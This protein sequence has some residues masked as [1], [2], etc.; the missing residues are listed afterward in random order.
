[1]R[2]RWW[3]KALRPL[4]SS[5]ADPG[6]G[7]VLDAPDAVLEELPDDAS[8]EAVAV[9]GYRMGYLNALVDAEEALLRANP[10]RR[11]S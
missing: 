1:M 8:K 11:R 4:W 9:E 5:E 2:G 6:V 10:W 7:P 3:E